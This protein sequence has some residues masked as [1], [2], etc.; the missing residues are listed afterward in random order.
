MSYETQSTTCL[1]LICLTLAGCSQPL[2]ETPALGTLERDRIELTADTS[3]PIRRVLVREGDR[4]TAGQALLEQHTE[5][6]DA[7]LAR[8]E[9]DESA[10]LAALAE[11]EQGPRAQAISQG[12]ARLVA[13]KSAADTARHELDRQKSL[14][15]RNFSSANTVD[16]LQGRYDEAVARV[17][18]AE[19]ALDELLE[20]TR[21]EII[22]QARSRYAAASATV[23]DLRITR[24][25]ATLRAPI[26]GVIEAIPYEL[27]ERP[28]PGATTLAM[29]ADKPVYARVHI[30]QLVR[31]RIQPGSQALVHVDSYAEALPATVRW[32]SKDASFTPYYALSQHD[33]TRLS[34]L[35]EIDLATEAAAELPIGIP[36][37]VVFPGIEP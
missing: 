29:L 3:E 15:Q 25:R 28:A 13:A 31:T 10:A 8:A 24:Q 7:A 33:R 35:A 14:V 2:S 20:G 30:P 12:R 4:V 19:A 32:V 1:L 27:G 18:E 17:D 22:D 6:V 34:F 36:V 23:R 37:E 9:A 16:I 26:D 5:R 21:N 11:A